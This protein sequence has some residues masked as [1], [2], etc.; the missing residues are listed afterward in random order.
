MV[1]V[2]PPPDKMGP[3]EAPAS[4]AQSE[5]I[6][7]AVVEL[8]TVVSFN[9]LP[10]L[11]RAFKKYPDDIAAVIVEPA[12]MNLGIVLPDAGYLAGIKE[13][14][15]RNGA[16]LIFDEVKTGVTIAPGGA[17]ERFGVQPDL[18]ALAKAIGG[19]LPCGA[20]GGRK[21]V[22]AVIEDKR[23][24]QMGTFNGNPLTLAASKVT[25]QDI[26]TPKAYAHFDALAEVLQ[27]GL[28]NVIAE[29]SL[30]FHVVTMAA[31]GGITYRA[32]RVRNYRDY[33]ETDK[34]SAYLSWLY[35]CNRGVLMAPGAEENWTLSVQHSQEDVQRY[36]DNFAEMA[37]DLRA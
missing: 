35:Q 36:V 33:L 1:S 13:I 23:V 29:N 26:L 8:T 28:Q 18:I 14:A 11:E 19:G 15:H 6:P 10:A 16:L 37:R 25:L 21:D 12:M 31:R 27:G 9:D 3:P 2:E 32:Q 22:M 5:G 20:I 4:W 17:T 30:P 34:A 7:K 24:S